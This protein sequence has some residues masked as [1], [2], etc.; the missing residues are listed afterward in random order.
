MTNLLQNATELFAKGGVVMFPLLLL[1][2][3][4]LA[5]ILYKTIQRLRLKAMD[6][7]R[8]KQIES[9]HER[10]QLQDALEAN[11]R[12]NAPVD[13]MILVALKAIE[14]PNFSWEMAKEDITRA[15]NAELAKYER[16]L[17]GLELVANVAPLLG[18]L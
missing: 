12:E 11:H 8:L 17:R 7:Y 14:N 5:V 16:H 4:M 18:L 10:A 3:Y 9:F 13:N 6:P 2:I 15:G 1:S